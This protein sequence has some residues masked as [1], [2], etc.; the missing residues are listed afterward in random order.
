MRSR[1]RH[2]A[3]LAATCL[4]WTWLGCASGL[5]PTEFTNPQF[6]FGFV[7]RLAVLPLENLAADRQAGE[8]ATRLL[9]TELLASGAVDVLEPG[10]VQAALDRLPGGHRSSPSREQT[11]ELGRTLGVQALILGSVTQSDFV[12]AGTLLIPAVTLDL[13]MVETETGAAVW[14]ATHSEKGAGLGARVLG[15]GAEPISETTRRC[16]RAILESLLG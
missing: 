16:V 6:D 15:T 3:L 12:R 13:H 14:A 10:E 11:I 2:F 5:R 9:I 7:E 8:R 4:G 1:P